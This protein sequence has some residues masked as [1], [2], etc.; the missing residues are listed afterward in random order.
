MPKKFKSLDWSDHF[1]NKEFRGELLGRKIGV[2]GY[3]RIGKK[4]IER[5]NAFKMHSTAI[6]R[7]KDKYKNNNYGKVKIYAVKEIDKAILNLDYLIVACP[8]N[9]ETENL[10]NI[11]I[12]KR[13]KPDAVIINVARGKIINEQDLYK[14][15]KNKIIREAIIDVWYKYPTSNNSKNLWPSNFPMH[16]LDNITMS[17]HTSA[18]TEQMLNRRFKIIGRNISNILV[19]KKVLNQLN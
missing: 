12:I 3:G 10:I 8:L 2:I 18:W 13:M 15:L 14:A 17:P 4:I 9:K 11:D 19:G 7:N 6:V 1:S 5:A 16:E